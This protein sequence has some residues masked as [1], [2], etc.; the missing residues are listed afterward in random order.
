MSHS[1]ILASLS[2]RCPMCN[3]GRA[4]KGPVAM[5]S[6]CS[7]CGAVFDRDEG[8]WTGAITLPYIFASFWVVGILSFIFAIGEIMNPNL[9]WIVPGSTVTLSAMVYPLSKRMWLG[10]YGEWGYLYP[11]PVRELDAAEDSSL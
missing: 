8:F 4:F 2:G 1:P 9:I 3:T 6:Q 7:E 10:M 11:D 5:H